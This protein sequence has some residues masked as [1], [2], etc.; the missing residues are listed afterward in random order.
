MAKLKTR[1]AAIK[2]VK[3]TKRGKIKAARAG[4]GHLLTHKGRKRKRQLRI[5]SLLCGKDAKKFKAMMPY[6]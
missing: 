1:K 4:R 2:R 3:M 5:K 6:R